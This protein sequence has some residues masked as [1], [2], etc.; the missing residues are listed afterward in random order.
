[1]YYNGSSWSSDRPITLMKTG[2]AVML[3]GSGKMADNGALTIG[4]ALAGSISFAA[5]SGSS[6]VVTRTGTTFLS[7]HVGRVIVLDDGKTATILTFTSATSVTVDLNGNTL[8]T[9]TFDNGDWLITNTNT[10][11]AM[12]AYM[13]LPANAIFAGS[14]AG[15]YWAT[16]T[17]GY[18]WTVF[19]N[20]QGVGNPVIP[21][22]PTPFSAVGPGVFSQTVNTDITLASISI[23]GGFLGRQ[24]GLKCSCNVVTG[25][26]TF[27]K[28]LRVKLGTAI[29]LSITVTAS[30]G[31]RFIG[32][33]I[34]NMGAEDRQFA[35]TAAAYMLSGGAT[36]TAA[37]RTIS[38]DTSAASTLAF[39]ANMV[40]NLDF[41]IFLGITVLGIRD[42]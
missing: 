8:S 30:A 20:T 14:A 2:A 28:G 24:G 22:S 17:T 23:P 25:N 13:Y 37:A 36:N 19:N 21:L 12:S 5:T 33:D 15:R 31:S 3:P 11:G 34:D 29:P 7:T 18:T 39:V 4:A 10:M 32:P 40:S 26:S 6:V 9:T 16:T 35:A 42:D 41:I 27:N 1:M 38:V